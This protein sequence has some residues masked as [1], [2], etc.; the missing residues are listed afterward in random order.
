MAIET[1]PKATPTHKA[2]GSADARASK[3]KGSPDAQGADAGALGFMAILSA[4]DDAPVDAALGA[5]SGLE[6]GADAAPLPLVDPAALLPVQAPLSTEAQQAANAANAPVPAVPGAAAKA[7]GGRNDA[8]LAA[9]VALAGAP[10]ARSKGLQRSL[11]QAKTD[12]AAALQD[13]QAASGGKTQEQP[14]HDFKLFAAMQAQVKL[15]SEPEPELMVAVLGAKPEKSTTERSLFAKQSSDASYPGAA[16]DMGP[17]DFSSGA[18]LEV[19]PVLETQAAEQV[20]YWI[21][22]DVQNAE[23]Q[24]DG[25]GENPVEVSISMQGNEAHVAFRT[26]EL[27]THSLLEG[28][29]AQLK[30]MLLREGVVLAGVSV[31]TSGTND[32]R[33]GERRPRQGTKIAQVMPAQMAPAAAIRRP[34]GS[35]GRSVDLFV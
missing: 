17:V 29:G 32:G 30:D 6:T 9:D 15:H 27:Q 35:S 2:N 12:Q 25:L 31:G 3:A 16:N 22:Q 24:L 14:Q 10:E 1:G 33:G 8:G 13:G 20:K 7:A 5:D 28:A 18:P 21:S 34:S 4:V 19:A 23:L 26:D 11:A